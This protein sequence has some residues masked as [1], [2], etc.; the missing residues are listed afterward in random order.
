MVECDSVMG[1]LV[2]SV[3]VDAFAASDG[4]L[5]VLSEFGGVVNGLFEN[6]GY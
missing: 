2:E 1:V 6:E 5:L 4:A 3:D